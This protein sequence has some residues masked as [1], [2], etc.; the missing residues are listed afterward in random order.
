MIFWYKKF[1]KADDLLLLFLPKENCFSFLVWPMLTFWW[2]KLCHSKKKKKLKVSPKFF[3]TAGLQQKLLILIES[4]NIFHWKLGKKE[5]GWGLRG[6]IRA[7]LG[8]VLW[9]NKETGIINGLFSNF[10]WGIHLKAWCSGYRN[11]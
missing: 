2:C 6:K 3:R 5:S 11:T 4:P 10:A 7:K 1:L 8:P 9:K